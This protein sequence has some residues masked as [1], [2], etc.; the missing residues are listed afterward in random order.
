M[1]I[2]LK[3]EIKARELE[4]RLLLGLVAAERGHT[5]LLGEQRPVVRETPELSPGL[6]H[7]TCLYPSR[8]QTRL[9]RQLRERGWMV[10]SQDEEHGLLEPTYDNYAVK[11]YSLENMQLAN[12]VF[13]WGRHDHAS[14]AD[15]YPEESDRLEIVGSPRIDLNR[16]E[17]TDFFQ[18]R[19]KPGLG[20]GPYLLFANNFTRVIGTN[21][22][23][24][25]VRHMRGAG[26]FDGDDD[27]FEYL[28]YE[29]A[30][31]QMDF[32]P[33]MIRAVRQVA[34]AH[35]DLTVV[36]RPHPQESEESWR[37]LIGPVPNVLVSGSGDIGRWMRGAVA[38]VQSGDTT[39]FEATVAGVPLIAFTP[40]R[41][42]HHWA[43]RFANR[44]GF[45]AP[46]VDGLLEVVAAIR[47]GSA[48]HDAV[49]AADRER[50]EDRIT[51]DPGRWAA[52]AIVDAWE[53]DDPGLGTTPVDE[54]VQRTRRARLEWRAKE[55]ARPALSRI[56]QVAAAAA[57]DSGPTS[58]TPYLTAQKFPAIA[59]DELVELVD[60]YRHALD[61]F[62]G[63]Q[64]TRI[65]PRLI[66]LER[67]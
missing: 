16:P 59:A 9:R 65:G 4:G 58:A 34:K 2:Y 12:R 6:Y 20:D 27:P 1:D 23:D 26:Y 8:G 18:G 17:L 24:T 57:S 43:A 52:D 33:H 46:D 7:D 36:V 62:H 56:R 32:L 54:L 61:R 31:A 10:T 42:E 21:R 3:M 49:L 67:G 39:A 63:V 40:V 25:F 64:A 35:P 11:R 14:L 38:V 41:G 22:I 55:I 37:D 45:N 13:A 66:G 28:Q 29:E 60:G 30:A 48:D 44:F 5:V 47:D 19:L 50:L 15:V 51:V 53:E